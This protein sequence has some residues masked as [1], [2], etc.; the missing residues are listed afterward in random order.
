MVGIASGVA[1]YK[2]PLEEEARRA[3][4]EREREREALERSSSASDRRG[5]Q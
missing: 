2:E 3:A 4:L 1:L 5:R